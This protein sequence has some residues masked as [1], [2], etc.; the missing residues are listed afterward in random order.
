MIAPE[1]SISRD[2]LKLAIAAHEKAIELRAQ[3]RLPA[4]EAACRRALA[5]YMEAEGAR[6]PDVANALVELGQILEIRDQLRSAR[7]C[8]AR[9]LAILTPRGRATDPDP[10]IVRLRLRARV[11]IAGIDRGLGAYA[12][13][14]RGFAVALREAT[15]AFG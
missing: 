10:D 13:A 14:D 6:H 9:A 15:R 12:A 5:L 3:T 8:H 2:P 4:A 1:A 7:A 11:F